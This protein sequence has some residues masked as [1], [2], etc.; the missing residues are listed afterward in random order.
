MNDEENLRFMM[1][2]DIM[3]ARWEK[4]VRKNTYVYIL[5]ASLKQELKV[6]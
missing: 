6:K 4:K 5:E 3:K 2:E 1:K